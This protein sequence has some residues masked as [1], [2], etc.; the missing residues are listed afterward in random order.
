MIVET[1]ESSTLRYFT[2]ALARRRRRQR[3]MSHMRVPLKIREPTREQLAI[4]ARRWSCLSWSLR[5][6]KIGGLQETHHMLDEGSLVV[7]GYCL[8]ATV[9]AVLV[10]LLHLKGGTAVG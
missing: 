5:R 4:V 1:E 2:A 7:D 9:T 8:T 6:S 10:S 3:M